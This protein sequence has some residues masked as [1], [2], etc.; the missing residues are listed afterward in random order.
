MNSRVFNIA[1]SLFALGNLLLA[2]SAQAAVNSY[3]FMHVTIDTPWHIF[4]FLLIGVFAPF[5]LMVILLWQQSFKPRQ[6]P[7]KDAQPPQPPQN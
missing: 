5:I 3:R 2:P 7:N 4:F 6:T 1:V